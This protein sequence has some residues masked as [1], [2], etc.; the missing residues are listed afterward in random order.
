[1]PPQTVIAFKDH[2]KVARTIDAGVDDARRDIAA[3]EAN[4]ISMREV[5][6]KLLTEGLASFQ[7]SFDTLLAGLREKTQKL[8]RELVSSS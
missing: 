5:T 2:G 4:G 6:D 7:K 8:G 3:L 1:M